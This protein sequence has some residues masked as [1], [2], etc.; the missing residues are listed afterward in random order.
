MIVDITEASKKM[1]PKSYMCDIVTFR[2]VK[3]I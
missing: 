2:K 3:S 1:L